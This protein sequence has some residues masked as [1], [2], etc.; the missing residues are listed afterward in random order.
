MAEN[1]M[2]ETTLVKELRDQAAER[3]KT[4]NADPF[5]WRK[6][7]AEWRAADEIERLQREVASYEARPLHCPCCDGD[8]L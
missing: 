8:H 3:S 7:T 5:E 1:T 4:C 6:T 2:A